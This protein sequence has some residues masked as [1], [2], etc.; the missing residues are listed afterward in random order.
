ME[1]GVVLRNI[2][3]EDRVGGSI[4]ESEDRIMRSRTDLYGRLCCS[5][6]RALRLSAVHIG[7]SKGHLLG[8]ILLFSGGLTIFRPTNNNFLQAEVYKNDL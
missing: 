1:E 2:I 5:H 8:R 3:V 4:G 7:R 6:T